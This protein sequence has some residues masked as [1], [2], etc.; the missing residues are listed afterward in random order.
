[1]HLQPYPFPIAPVLELLAKDRRDLR[2]RD[3]LLGPEELIDHALRDAVF[4]QLLDVHG[5][6]PFASF[7]HC[8]EL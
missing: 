7:Q 6:L 4:Q 5:R 3:P 1:V 2:G 8:S